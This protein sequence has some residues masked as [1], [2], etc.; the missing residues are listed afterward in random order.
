MDRE[1]VESQ[2]AVPQAIFGAQADQH[3]SVAFRYLSK[4]IGALEA[5]QA[6]IVAAG[7]E[8]IGDP[9]AVLDELCNEAAEANRASE[10][11]MRQYGIPDAEGGYIHRGRQP[12]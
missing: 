2:K 8:G 12:R 11:M 9:I 5:A 7:T 6:N 3:G 10:D 1:E 4:L